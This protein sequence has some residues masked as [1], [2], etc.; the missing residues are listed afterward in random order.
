M[1]A[2]RSIIAGLSAIALPLLLLSACG[3]S[4]TSPSTYGTVIID[5][6]PDAAAATWHLAGPGGITRDGTGDA[7]LPDQ[8]TGSYTVTWGAATGYDTPA[9]AT[10]DLDEGQTITFGGAY[11]VTGML[12]PDTPDKLMENFLTMYE[13]M[14][15][16]ALAPLLHPQYVMILQQSTYDQWP[17]LGPTLDTAEEQRIHERMFSGVDVTDPDGALV[18]AIEDIT[19]PYFARSGAWGTSLPS[20]QIPDTPY[21]LYEVE[22][23]MDRGVGHTILKT[24]GYLKAYVAAVDT[25]VAGETRSCYRLRGLV[26]LTLDNKA[27]ESFSWGSSKA[28]FR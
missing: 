6:Q 12:F 25:V 18:P 23:W 5:V 16:A 4:S 24:T 28:L 3:G 27:S 7:T 21:A 17:S 10:L 11:A 2:I 8:R 9:A 22:I 15:P 19:F 1:S 13:T 26:D 14:N 20:D